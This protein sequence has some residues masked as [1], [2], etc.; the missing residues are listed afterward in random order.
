MQ[1]VTSNAVAKSFNISTDNGWY[2]YKIGTKYIGLYPRSEGA[3]TPITT[4]YG[5]M[6]LSAVK[7]L[8]LP[9][10]VGNIQMIAGSASKTGG[11]VLYIS[12]NDTRADISL[13]T[14]IP[15]YY[16]SPVSFTASNCGALFYCFGDYE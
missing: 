16:A 5:N 1:S 2:I 9:H 12:M 14:A 3:S 8:V 10:N 11:G 6:Y 7:S 4:S 13:K 15:F